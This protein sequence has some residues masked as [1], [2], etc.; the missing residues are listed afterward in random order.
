MACRSGTIPPEACTTRS[1]IHPASTGNPRPPGLSSPGLLYVIPIPTT[2]ALAWESLATTE[3]GTPDTE[4]RGAG[5]PRPAPPP[6]H[7]R[8]G[9]R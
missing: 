6:E 5:D 2:V 9:P 7:P 4:S 3:A 8:G 1:Y